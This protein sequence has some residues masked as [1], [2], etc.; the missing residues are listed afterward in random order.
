METEPRPAEEIAQHL[1][2]LFQTIGNSFPY[3]KSIRW[4][5]GLCYGFVIIFIFDTL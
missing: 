2:E 5:F 1:Q 3:E 4:K